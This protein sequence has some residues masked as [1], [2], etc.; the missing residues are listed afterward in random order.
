MVE[1]ISDSENKLVPRFGTT[2]DVAEL[3]KVS[4]RAVERLTATGRLAGAFKV[5]GARRYDMVVLLKALSGDG[6]TGG[7]P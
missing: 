7:R 4:T 2:K 6:K 5:G 1:N 3:L